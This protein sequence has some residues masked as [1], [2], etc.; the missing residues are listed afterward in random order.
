MDNPTIG[1]SVV[2]K[3][4]RYVVNKSLGD[5]RWNLKCTCGSRVMN[6]HQNEFNAA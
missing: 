5:G 2:Y 1:Q 3:G 4:K 6:V